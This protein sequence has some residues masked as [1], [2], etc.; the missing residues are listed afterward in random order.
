MFK[1]LV[2]KNRSFRGFDESRRITREELCGLAEL[3]RYCP[4]ATNNQLLRFALVSEPAEAEALNALVK[5]G[6]LLP[7]K[8]LPYPG[9]HPVAFIVILQDVSNGPGSKW[10]AMDVGIAAQT[11]LLGAAEQGLGG[12][13][14]GNF[15]PSE[16]AALLKLPDTLEPKLVLALGKPDETVVITDVGEDGSTKYYRDEQDVHYVPKRK[17]EDLIL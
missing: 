1:D 9:H 15:R 16:V 17:L 2:L 6:G 8:H 11:I 4:S 3:A 5:L 7:E 12:C 10:V 14:I 13:M